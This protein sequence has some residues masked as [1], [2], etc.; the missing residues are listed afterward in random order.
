MPS[1][2]SLVVSLGS[3]VSSESEDLSVEG[4]PRWSPCTEFGETALHCLVRCP[5]A[6]EV[7]NRTDAIFIP[8]LDTADSLWQWWL[9]LIEALKRRPHWRMRASSFATIL[10]KLL[11]DRNAC[12]F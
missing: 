1:E 2:G 3:Q 9:H 6:I 10:W 8:Q 12:I 5:F 11:I 7:W 4:F